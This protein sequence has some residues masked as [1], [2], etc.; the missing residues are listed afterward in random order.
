M[1]GRVA[2][3]G[4]M[5]AYSQA[6]IWKFLGRD[7]ECLPCATFEELFHAVL[8][9]RATHALLPVENSTTGSV[10]P[11]Y[12]LLLEHPLFIQR[13]LILRIEHALLAA[14]NTSLERIR[15]VT[16]HPQA[17]AQCEGYIR[18]HGWEAV[19]AYDTAGAAGQLAESR[20]P[21]TAVIASEIAAQLYGLQV[22]D[23]SIQDWAENYTRF[24]LLG[25][26][27]APYTSQ[28]KTTVVFATAHVPGALYHCLGEFASRNLNL[29]RIE[30][31]PDRK[32]PWHY[33]FYVDVEGHSA[34]SPLRAALQALA[35]HTTFLRI[36]GSYPAA[37]PGS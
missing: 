36:L 11:A 15:R 1:K 30:S 28:A 5:G 17:L 27:P 21:E 34:D 33:L 19:T 9:G 22:L 6:A 20:D 23:R 35:A 3:Q 25:M 10:H 4:A 2:F 16:S 26:Q 29:T 31:R 8:D 7:T 13:E 32:Q 18:R 12:D 24:F 37:L 14:P